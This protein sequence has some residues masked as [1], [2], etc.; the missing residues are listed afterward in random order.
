MLPSRL[1]FAIPLAPS[2][3]TKK[4]LIC[5]ANH[6]GIDGRDTNCRNTAT[7]MCSCA[8]IASGGIAS[9]TIDQ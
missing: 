6:A 8:N 2:H 7:A 5:M 1:V 9:T 3:R 4:S